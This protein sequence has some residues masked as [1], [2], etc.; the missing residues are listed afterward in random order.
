M[1]N[2]F[3]FSIEFTCGNIERKS[4]MI[5]MLIHKYGGHLYMTVLEMR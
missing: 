2:D 3:E 5:M 1:G 4:I